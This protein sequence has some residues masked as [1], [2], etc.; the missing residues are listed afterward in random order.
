MLAT[1]TIYEMKRI[2]HN[3]APCGTK[4]LNF[5]VHRGVIANMYKLNHLQ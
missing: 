5:G 4:K 2:G 1:G 3:T